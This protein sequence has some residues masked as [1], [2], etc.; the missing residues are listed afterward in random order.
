M[1]Y[2]Y[3]ALINLVQVTGDDAWIVRSNMISDMV[4]E[5]IKIIEFSTRG[6]NLDKAA[7]LLLLMMMMTGDG[8]I[9]TM[10]W[11]LRCSDVER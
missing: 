10:S 8:W 5:K 3:Q 6:K 11:S 9:I 7:K 1:V 4:V 2:G